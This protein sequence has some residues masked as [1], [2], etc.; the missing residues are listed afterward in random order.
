MKYHLAR[1]VTAVTVTATV[2]PLLSQT[3]PA[4]KPSFEVASVKPNKSVNVRPSEEFF[5]NRYLGAHVTLRVLIHAAYGI[6]SPYG[7]C[8][9]LEGGP[10]WIDSEYFDV[11]GKVGDGTIPASLAAKDRNDQIRLMLQTLLADRF[12]LKVHREIKEVPVYEMVVS[13]NGPKLHKATGERECPGIPVGSTACPARLS[14]GMGRGITAKALDLSE[15]SQ[16][17]SG[18]ADRPILD[19]TGIAGLFDIKTTPWRPD[20]YGP[21]FAAE[22]HVDPEVLPTIFTMLQ[23]QLGLRLVSSRGPVEVVVID[24]VEPPSEN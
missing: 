17:L 10:N 23:E 5:P 19:R 8:H 21:H 11:E 9:Y 18:F 13:R 16:F 6:P 7:Q 1:L 2:I 14:G 20:R 22:T 4:Q 15:L 12:Q 3:A 24:H